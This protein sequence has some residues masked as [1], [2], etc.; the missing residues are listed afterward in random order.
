MN[1]FLF[2]VFAVFVI[3]MNLFVFFFLPETKGTP[4][5]EMEIVWKKHGFWSRY[6]TDVKSDKKDVIDSDV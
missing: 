1:F 4:I 3:L 2:I 5:E 6:T